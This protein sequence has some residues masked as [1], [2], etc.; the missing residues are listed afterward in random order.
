MSAPTATQG[1]DTTDRH[2]QRPYG[3][4]DL[5]F[6]FHTRGSPGPTAGSPPRRP[7]PGGLTTSS[8]KR[9]AAGHKP[10]G[11]CRTSEAPAS[12]RLGVLVSAGYTVRLGF[13]L[14]CIGVV[15]K[16]V[17]GAR[18]VTASE[19]LDHPCAAGGRGLLGRGCLGHRCPY[20]EPSAVLRSPR[21]PP[22]S[23]SSVVGTRRSSCGDRVM[24]RSAPAVV[25]LNGKLRYCVPAPTAGCARSS[26]A[27]WC[28]GRRAGRGGAGRGS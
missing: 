17:M 27:G 6:H 4:P 14:A 26:V 1:H 23:S 8:P 5:Q 21:P 18:V 12:D 10:N 22:W 20:Q 7:F 13:I 16:S 19:I 3:P 9:S 24:S 25:K 28:P 2:G 15:A 11:C